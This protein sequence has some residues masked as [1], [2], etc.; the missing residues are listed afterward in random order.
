MSLTDTHLLFQEEN[1]PYKA[2]K[3]LGIF[4]IIESPRDITTT[5][6]IRRIV[7]HYEAYKVLSLLPTFQVLG[8]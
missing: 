8:K 2:A 3:D 7:S 4:R 6:I 5:S 1:D